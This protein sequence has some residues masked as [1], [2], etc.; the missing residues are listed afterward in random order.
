MPRG[1]PS[2]KQIADD[3][4]AREREVRAQAIAQEES[5]KQEILAGWTAPTLVSTASYDDLPI[6]SK[7]P[8][9]GANPFLLQ[10]SV[11]RGVRSPFTL[12]TFGWDVADAIR[13]CEGAYW[14]FPLLKNVVDVMA[15]LANSEIYLKGGN[16]K[17][18]DFI[19]AWKDT[20]YF[21]RFCE[22]WFR[23]YFR[24]G[25]VA[26][27]RA[28]GEY[29]DSDLA[30]MT[31]MFGGIKRV[32]PVHYTILNPIHIRVRPNIT[33][34]N[35]TYA[36]VLDA[37]EVQ[38]VLNPVTP[39]DKA[40]RKSFTS[41]QILQMRSGT[42][43]AVPLDPDLLNI[44]FYKKQPYEPLAVPMAYPLLSDIND[45]MA[46]KQKDA[47]FVKKM[48]NALLLVNVGKPLDQYNLVSNN[49]QNQEYIQKFFSQQSVARVMIVD[50]TVDVNWKI[51]NVNEVLGTQKY[52]QIDQDLAIGLN[53]ILFNSDEKFANTSIKVQVFVE[54][55]KEAR[56]AFLTFFQDEVKRVCQNIGA[57][58]YPDI[59]FEE[60]SLKDELQFNR[61]Y[62]Q[63]AQLGILTPAELFDAM[64]TGKMPTADESLANQEDYYD[65]KKAGY[66]FPLVGGNNTIGLPVGTQYV[67]PVPP[68]PVA[69]PGVKKPTTT[70]NSGKTSPGRP[71]G[72]G[73]TKKAASASVE[74][75]PE[76]LFS[77]EKLMDVS[78]QANK[79][80][81]LVCVALRK[82]Y[83]VKRMT[84]AQKELAEEVA[85][86][87]TAN[88]PIEDWRIKVQEYVETPKEISPEIKEQIESL[89][90]EHELSP[91]NANLLRLAAI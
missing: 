2:N 52:A 91:Y 59:Y 88:E 63:L 11:L 4:A 50:H 86:A 13:L 55:L 61:I 31:Q 81:G 53:A 85:T 36:R 73:G 71:S 14:S 74:G 87:L 54:R 66:Y 77:K 89:A 30:K 20:I 82:H 62:T 19:S 70:T 27:Y 40:F 16:K 5:R 75:D 76:P 33:Q 41:Q 12:G 17:T 29:N 42:I 72:S 49:K 65:Q 60:I 39:E 51:P 68:P 32:I 47:E 7:M 34:S 43:P 38:R 24:S 15:E 3:A 37:W 21:N 26:S 9:T 83:G 10:F 25:T 80:S 6:R 84:K 8:G 18:R 64:D 67:A 45:K 22:A 48:D 23:E 1:R 35:P 46:M 58:S 57:Q 90:A 28:D 69:A 56:K 78:G 79:V 44:T